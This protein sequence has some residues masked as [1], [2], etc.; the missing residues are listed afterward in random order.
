METDP[1]QS[2]GYMTYIYTEKKP[3]YDKLH[4]ALGAT[5]RSASP[6][7]RHCSTVAVERGRVAKICS[8]LCREGTKEV[9]PDHLTGR[10][11]QY[12]NL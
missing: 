9:Q 8:R 6:W 12:G 11:A 10:T 3:R 1:K 4:G 5:A 2:L 7:I